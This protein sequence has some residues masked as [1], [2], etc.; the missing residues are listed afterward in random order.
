MT[1][2]VNKQLSERKVTMYDFDPDATAATA[3]GWVDMRDFSK[4]LVCVMRTIGTSVMT[5]T[6]DANTASDGGGDNVTISTKTFTAGQPDA[7]G[8]TVFLEII[9]SQIAQK[10]SEDG[11]DYRYASAAISVATGTDEAVVTYVQDG[12]R[13]AGDGLTADLIA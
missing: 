10:A 2:N 8:D 9:A 1:L 3:V 12:A 7:V 13:F 6:I 11:K 4:L 5:L